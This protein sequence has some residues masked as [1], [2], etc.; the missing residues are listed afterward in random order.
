MTFEWIEEQL[1]SEYAIKAEVLGPESELSEEIIEEC[2]VQS[3]R[4]AE[5]QH[6]AMNRGDLQFA[7]KVVRWPN[8]D[9]KD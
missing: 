5:L 8:S 3:C 1:K 9:P 6:L 2:E 7:A 4:A